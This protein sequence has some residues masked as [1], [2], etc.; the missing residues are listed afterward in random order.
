MPLYPFW[1]EGSPTKIDYRRK[2]NFIET[3]WRTWLVLCRLGDSFD[4][5]NVE[6]DIRRTLLVTGPPPPAI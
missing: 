3:Y 4:L 1:G 2:G 5:K 6:Q